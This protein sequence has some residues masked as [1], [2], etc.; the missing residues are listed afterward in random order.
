MK[1]II[2]MDYQASTPVDPRVLEAMLPYF[3]QKYGNSA[4]KQHL[5]GIEADA[6]VEHARKQVAQCIGAKTEEVYFTSGA[7]ESNNLAIRGYLETFKDHENHWTTSNVEHASV[8]NLFENLSSPKNS[9]SFLKVDEQ[10]RLDPDLIKENLQ[11]E[12]RMVS[13][14]MANNEIGTLQAI[15]EIGKICKESGILFHTDAA[16][17]VG[18][19]PIDVEKMHIDLLS[20]SGHKNY[21]PKG[22]GALY[23]RSKNPQIHLIPQILG[24]GHER[25][26]RSGTLN[27][28]GIVALGK[29]CEISRLEMKEESLKLSRLRDRMQKKLLEGISDLKVNG[30]MEHRLPHNLS[31]SIPDIKASVLM[32]NLKKDVAFATGSA[33]TSLHPKPSHVLKAIGL[34][35]QMA[36]ATLRFSLGRFTSEDEVD[37]VCKRILEEVSKIRG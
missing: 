19:I 16:Q 8:M 30:D 31:L 28:P 23:V 27:V 22:V 17:A 3:T 5:F 9:V 37:Q 32:M 18:K 29:A 15:E 10:G 25:G 1:N 24:G 14:M 33:C 35:D 36:N 7:T 11:E 4:S 21:A 20:I 6:A 12:T 26:L 2:Y 34:T 13:V